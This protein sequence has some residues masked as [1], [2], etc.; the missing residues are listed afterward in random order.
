MLGKP[1]QKGATMNILLTDEEIKR[2]VENEA[3]LFM[4]VEESDRVIAR[5]QLRNVVKWGS[6][7]CREHRTHIDPEMLSRFDCCD[8]MQELRKAAGL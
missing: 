6:S 1:G 5:A 2:V 7:L 3:S 8:C 4:D